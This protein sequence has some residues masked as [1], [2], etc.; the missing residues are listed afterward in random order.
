MSTIITIK[1]TNGSGKSSVVRALIDHLGKVATLRF[2]NKDAGYRCRYGDGALFVLGKYKSACGGLDS[3]FSYK[4]AADDVMICLDALAAKGH[5][6]C[7]G[8]IAVNYYGFGRVTRFVSEQK[9]KGNHVIFARLD[10]PVELCVERVQRRR[11][12]GGNYRPFN[13]EHLLHKHEALLRMQE[14]LRE[15]G[16]DA[17][18]LPHEDPLQTLLRWL[19]ERNPVKTGGVALTSPCPTAS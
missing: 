11:R 7:E 19:A 18:V 6:V 1:G 8:I 12:L 9:A 15:A 13:S 17:R 10:T 3:S 14:K 2:H 5:V 4:G 16:H